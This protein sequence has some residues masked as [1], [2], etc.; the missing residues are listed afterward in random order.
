M[1]APDYHPTPILS[2]PSKSPEA[3]YFARGK[4]VLGPKA[5]GFLVKL[6]KAKAGNV[7]L[8]R[9][10]IEMASTK[11]NPAE[12]VGRV[13]QPRYSDSESVMIGGGYA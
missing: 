1:N 12:Y 3:D 10:A 5:G 7:A 4:E 9:A 6:L 8:A 13:I 2:T 11:Q